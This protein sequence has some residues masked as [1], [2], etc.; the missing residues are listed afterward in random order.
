MAIDYAGPAVFRNA[1][2]D[3]TTVE[4]SE[5]KPKTGTWKR[6]EVQ[7]SVTSPSRS[8]AKVKYSITGA[9][10]GCTVDSSGKVLIGDQAGTI[11]VRA[12]D[13]ASHYDEVAI[14]ITAR[15]AAAN[16]PA[17]KSTGEAG[18]EAEPAAAPPDA[19][20]PVPAGV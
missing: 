12:G 16:P 19:G 10:L 8:S 2:A 14:A 13:G 11:T 9:A 15:P 4:A 18:S 7:V 6:N 5:P 1:K 17:P 20:E 3:K